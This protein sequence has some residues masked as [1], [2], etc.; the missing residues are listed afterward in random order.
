M[1]FLWWWSLLL[2]VAA[3][4]TAAEG[5]DEPSL[6]SKGVPAAE[7][8]TPTLQ[9]RRLVTAAKTDKADVSLITLTSR[10]FDGAISDGN[11]W[12]IEFYAPWCSHCTSFLPTYIEIAEE[13]HKSDKRIKVAKINGSEEKALASRFDVYGFPTFYVIVGWSV[14]SFE[15][16]RTK[17]NLIK[18]ADGGYKQM[19][20][21]PFYASPFGPIGLFQ[22]GL[23]SSGIFLSDLFLWLQD[24]LGLSQLIAGMVLFGSMFMGIFVIIVLMAFN[25][26]VKPKKD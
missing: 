10:T 15:G 4:Y 26:K 5:G 7:E 6:T 1:R 24:S 25:V 12:L 8:T 20:S 13:F 19:S 2:A 18:F 11:V 9:D 17:Q 23:I 16:Q 14:Y 22:G 21:I 3:H